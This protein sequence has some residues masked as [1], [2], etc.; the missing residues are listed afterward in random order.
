MSVYNNGTHW[1][2]R[3]TGT[4]F[5]ATY[6]DKTIELNTW[7][8]VEMHWDG[9]NGTAELFVNGSREI[10]IENINNTGIAPYTFYLGVWTDYGP[11]NP[12]SIYFDDVVVSNVYVGP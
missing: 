11:G 7:Y 12:H 2:W 8:S 9:V 3:L 5:K 6:V 4:D 1:V 10:R